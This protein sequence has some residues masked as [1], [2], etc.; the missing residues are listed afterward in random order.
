[1]YK[2]LNS[3]PSTRK[4]KAAYLMSYSVPKTVLALNLQESNQGILV[5]EEFTSV[6]DERL[7][8]K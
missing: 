3:I 7:E 8:Q 5:M 2:A 4:K 6:E 1:M